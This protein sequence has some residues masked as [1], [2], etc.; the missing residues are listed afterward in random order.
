MTTKNLITTLEDVFVTT[1]VAFE[2][3]NFKMKNLEHFNA[4]L[5]ELASRAD[6][7]D[8]DLSG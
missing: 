3:Y 4:D 1:I 5:V 2:R 8:R 7:A 6:C